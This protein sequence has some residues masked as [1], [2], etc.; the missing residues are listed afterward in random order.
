MIRRTIWLTAGAV[1]GIAGYRRLDRAAKALTGRLV[2]TGPGPVAT[3]PAVRQSAGM[4]AV[5]AQLPAR[6]AS[7]PAAA[8]FRAAA[9]LVRQLRASAGFA[10][11]VRAGMDEYLDARQ[12][13][14]D[15]QHARSRNTLGGRRAAI[16]AGDHDAT[17]D[18]R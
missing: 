16:G 8:V 11:E 3:L 12:P 6:S 17:K 15:R 9:W 18:G 2:T 1:I 13:N 5:P 14:I 4:P 10:A 7:S